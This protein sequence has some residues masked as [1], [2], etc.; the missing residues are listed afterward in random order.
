MKFPFQSLSNPGRRGVA[1]R[2]KTPRASPKRSAR[3]KQSATSGSA[4]RSLQLDPGSQN[5][6]VVKKAMRDLSPRAARFRERVPKAVG[7]AGGLFGQEQGKSPV[8]DKTLQSTSL[9]LATMTDTRGGKL[10]SGRRLCPNRPPLK[11]TV[12][13]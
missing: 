9:T 2:G 6:V 10:F 13:A 4:S 11:L 3:A 7:V 12:L 1:P 5:V 8:I